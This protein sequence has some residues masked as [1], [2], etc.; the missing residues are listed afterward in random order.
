MRPPRF[1]TMAFRNVR[2]N[3]RRSLITLAAIVL[4]VTMVTVMRGFMEGAQVLMVDDAVR[5]KS[6]ALQIHRKGYLANAAS[7]PTALAMRHG[8][9]LVEQMRAVK[10]VT[11]VAGRLRFSG[12]VSNGVSQTM[13]S[14]RGVDLAE[15]PKVCPRAVAGV[16]DGGEALREGDQGQA[17]LGF[18]LARSFGLAVA[19]DKRPTVNL[20][21]SS[22][23]GRAN[24]LEVQVK[25]LTVSNLP[26]ENKRVVTVPLATAQSLLGMEEQVT[27][28]VLAVDDLSRVDRVAESLR[29]ALGPEYEVHTWK[30][31]MPF[32]RD[33]VNRQNFVLGTVAVVLFVIVLTGIINTMLMSV[34]ERVREIGTM[35][36]VGVRRR[37]V[38][39]LFVLE[40]GV[41]GVAGGSAGAALGS[42][43]VGVLGAVGLPVQLSGTSGS[44][45][46]RPSVSAVFV[47]VAVLIAFIGALLAAAYPAYRAS[48]QNPV[49]ALRSA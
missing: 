44:S 43:A 23:E 19:V 18:E 12:L 41:L 35:L 48:R 14:G 16:A 30:E 40:A 9:A 36:A 31:V 47:A 3:R 22:P 34:F 49:D 33:V 4:G 6:G 17:L 15:E 28:Y 2:R 45:M 21:S 10:G 39:W 7:D 38:L 11:A 8:G 42:A 37:Q 29:A 1:F 20:Q 26:F 13:F 25:G 46:L 32:V 5:G 24:S 27:E